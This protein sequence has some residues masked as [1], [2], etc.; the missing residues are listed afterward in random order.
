MDDRLFC[1]RLQQARKKAGLS[2]TE[3]AFA[4]YTDQSVIS[5][6]ETGLVMPRVDRVAAMAELYGVS[7]DW[8]CGMEDQKDEEA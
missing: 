1:E 3:V 2:G 6:Y 5:R 8:L 4:L 7:M